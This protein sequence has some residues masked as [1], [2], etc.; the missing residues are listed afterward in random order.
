SDVTSRNFKSLNRRNSNNHQMKP[1]IL[2]CFVFFGCVT[3]QANTIKTIVFPKAEIINK[4]TA[5][6]PFKLIDH[7]IVVE[8]EL[9]G[10]KGNFIIDTGS[11][12]LILNKVHFKQQYEH[13]KK[14]NA[15]SGVIGI[16]DNPL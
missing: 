8:A 7:L 1:F 13:N 15:T 11:E 4:N 12:T 9:L 10:K 2:L 6:I 3:A 14:S 5:R 16:I